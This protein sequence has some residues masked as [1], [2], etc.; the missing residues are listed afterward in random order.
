MFN[1]PKRY[2]N[3]F[4]HI[5]DFHKEYYHKNYITQHIIDKGFV[6]KGNSELFN[7]YKKDSDS[8]SFFDSYNHYSY[9]SDN[10]DY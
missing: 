3:I 10:G 4:D 8:D 6:L 9:S 5:E 1:N 7:F 2:D